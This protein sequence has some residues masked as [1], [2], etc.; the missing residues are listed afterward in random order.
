MNFEKL[1]YDEYDFKLMD[2]LKVAITR[3]LSEKP[4]LDCRGYEVVIDEITRVEITKLSNDSKKHITLSGREFEFNV[5]GEIGIM[6]RVE[7]G[8]RGQIIEFWVQPAKAKF[9]AG[10][11]TFA[12]TD[13]SGF[14]PL[15]VRRF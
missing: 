12:I 10:S 5:E 3:L 9:E 11:E 14:L 13:L 7:N 8:S 1:E 4:E 15:G 6:Q 2:S